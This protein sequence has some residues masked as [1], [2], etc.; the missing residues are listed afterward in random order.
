MTSNSKP[1]LDPTP[2]G[3]ELDRANAVFS[4]AKDM[5]GFVPAGVRL[6]G[7]SPPLLEAFAGNVGYFRNGTKLSPALTA[8]IRYLVSEKVG[9]Q[10][11][12]DMNEGFLVTSIF[13][14]NSAWST[15]PSACRKRCFRISRRPGYAV[16]A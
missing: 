14:R 13:M 15:Y 3:D 9:C 5:L 1:L 11:C 7:I 8:M 12:I 10:F 6:Y 16:N 4:M 2:P